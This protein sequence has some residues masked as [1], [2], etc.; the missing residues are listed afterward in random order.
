MRSRIQ[1]AAIDTPYPQHA[2]SYLGVEPKHL[3]PVYAPEVVAEAI[4]HCA[5]P[6]PAAGNS[7][8]GEAP[9]AAA[10][11]APVEQAS[12]SGA[13]TTSSTSRE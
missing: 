6:A 1:P 11:G 12:A 10:Q 3:P 8:A 2:K 9:Q 4:L 5:E 7:T 13:A